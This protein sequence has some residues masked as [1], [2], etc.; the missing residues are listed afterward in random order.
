M[1]GIPIGVVG[2]IVSGEQQ[3]FFVKVLDDSE[4]T[5]GFLI[6]NSASTSDMKDGFDDWVEDEGSLCQ[7]FSEAGWKINW[8]K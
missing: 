6:I 5:G 8:S 7:Y 2:E 4:F 3:G 1:M